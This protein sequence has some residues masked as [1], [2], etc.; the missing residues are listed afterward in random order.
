MKK[1]ILSV[2]LSL[3]CLS[4]HAEWSKTYSVDYLM[5]DGD[6]R[7]S[8]RQTALEQ[9]KLKASNEAGSYVE[10]TTTLHEDGKLTESIQVIGASM[11]KLKLLSEAMSVNKSG[12][13]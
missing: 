10:S 12:Q 3:V 8:A 9:V 6:N 5:G 4:V 7:V 1:L 2:V 11:V 13:S